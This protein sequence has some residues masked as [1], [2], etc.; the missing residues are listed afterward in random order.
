MLAKL[1]NIDPVSY[2]IRAILHII[3]GNTVLAYTFTFVFYHS[4]QTLL[5]VDPIGYHEHIPILEHLKMIDSYRRSLS[6]K[7]TMVGRRF[8]VQIISKIHQYTY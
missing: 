6:V 1:V 4:K 3:L 5:L 2:P 8:N 7:C